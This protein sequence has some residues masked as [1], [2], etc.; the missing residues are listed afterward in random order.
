MPEI[1]DTPSMTI[2]ADF[3]RKIFITQTV[4][5]Q[6]IFGSYPAKIELRKTSSSIRLNLPAKHSAAEI[7][8]PCKGLNRIIG[9]RKR[10]SALRTGVLY[11]RKI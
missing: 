4:R 10:L 8:Q 11:D 5:Y 9:L 1:P 3:Q 2:A 6:W 7:I